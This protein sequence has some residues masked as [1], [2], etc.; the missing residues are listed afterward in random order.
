M[1]S[2]KFE[3]VLGLCIVG[4]SLF[5][6]AKQNQFGVAD[7]R[8]VEFTAPTRIGDVLLPQGYYRVQHSMEGQDHVMVFQQLKAKKP[9]EA[10]VKCQLVP[11]PKKADR[12]EQ[13]F[14]VNAANQRVLH[15]LVFR[16][17]SAQHVF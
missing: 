12:D 14:G 4:L 13:S 16:G 17:D 5:A 15:A 8:N 3:A 10:R 9:A 2:F 7:V 1:R 6:L 11:L